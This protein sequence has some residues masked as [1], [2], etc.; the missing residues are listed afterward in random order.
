MY[1]KI[2]E[3]RN[4]LNQKAEQVDVGVEVPVEAAD[5]ARRRRGPRPCRSATARAAST[6]TRLPSRNSPSVLTMFR[7]MIS[8]AM[9]RRY[10]CA[11][12][13]WNPPSFPS[14]CSASARSRPRRS[15]PGERRLPA[16]GPQRQQQTDDKP[17]G[18]DEHEPIR[19]HAVEYVRRDL[20][21]DPGAERA[22]DPDDREK[23]G[24]LAPAYRCRWRTP[25][26]A[27]AP[28]D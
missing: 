11:I 23:G 18:R 19:P 10:R 14:G 25:T 1:L 2:R 27:T 15:L 17:A 21:T 24:R 9:Y 8:S 22:A 20:G 28:S 26:A 12:T 5:P 7:I 13:S 6:S 3:T 16:V 4:S